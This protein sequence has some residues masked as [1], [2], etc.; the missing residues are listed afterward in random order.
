M[1]EGKKVCEQAGITVGAI[2][3]SPLRASGAE[4]L[5]KGKEI[6]DSLL[7]EAAKVAADEIKVVPHH[8]YSTPY[9]QEILRV[10]THRALETAYERCS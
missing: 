5:L 8:G 6:S 2:A 9:L 1:G 3:A 4:S 10:Q 7:K